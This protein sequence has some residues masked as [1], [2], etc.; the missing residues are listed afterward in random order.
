MPGPTGQP[1]STGRRSATGP[2][3]STGPT[4]TD[5]P[6]GVT[7]P[8]GAAFPFGDF[9]YVYATG[10]SGGYVLTT[11][12][13]APFNN[14]VSTPPNTKISLS[15]NFVQVQ[16][17]GLYQITWGFATG[18]KTPPATN[19][20]MSLNYGPT[21]SN[22]TNDPFTVSSSKL[23]TM[24]HFTQILYVNPA[25]IQFIGLVALTNNI[26]L[27]S[28]PTTDTTVPVAYMT[29]VKISN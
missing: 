27:E 20:T 2:T 19:G 23:R 7:G 14:I 26:G 17:T 1:G 10:P 9:A 25:T 5:G 6:T 29:L 16:D 3:G 8:S 21:T 22:L 28:I 18:V 12:Q 13:Q 4:G 15:G 11:G 24:S